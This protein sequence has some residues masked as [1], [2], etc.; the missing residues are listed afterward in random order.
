MNAS[1]ASKQNV[2]K[3]TNKETVNPAPKQNVSPAQSTEHTTAPDAQLNDETTW[4]SVKKI[5]D[6][7]DSAQDRKYKIPRPDAQAKARLLFNYCI[8]ANKN[9][10]ES[11]HNLFIIAEH[12][13][14]SSPTDLENL[15]VL[16]GI[17]TFFK[18]LS[19]KD[20]STYCYNQVTEVLSSAAV[21]VT[22]NSLLATSR[23][24]PH[25]SSSSVAGRFVKRVS[26]YVTFILLVMAMFYALYL[27]WNQVVDEPW[28]IKQDNQTLEYALW[29]SFGCVGALVHLLNHALTTTRL[30]IFEISEERKVWPRIL[31]G[32]LFGFVLPWLL[33]TPGGLIGAENIALG[34]VAAFFGGYSV[35]FAIGLLER[36]LSAF[37]PETDLSNR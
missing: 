16:N 18:S 26:R 19:N 1:E 36:V 12:Y 20:K 14:A 34:T 6:F 37:L 7:E 5:F 11:V 30:Q 25:D 8:S 17:P 2:A 24:D 22:I 4:Q 15:E 23:M 28:Q 32:G 29:V 27:T 13:A 3:K 10:P 35:R 9:V 33:S 31:L 21:P